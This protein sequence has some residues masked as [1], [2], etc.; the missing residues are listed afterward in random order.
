MFGHLFLLILAIGRVK[1]NFTHMN[2][3]Q[4]LTL[5]VR[6]FSVLLTTCF[7]IFHKVDTYDKEIISQIWWWL[8][9]SKGIKRGCE[10]IRL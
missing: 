10:D 6:L 2:I 3:R 8:L 5:R 9:H 1:Q 4:N 7:K